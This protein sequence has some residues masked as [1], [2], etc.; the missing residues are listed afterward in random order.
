MTQKHVNQEPVIQENVPVNQD[1]VNEVL[2]NQ[3][4]VNIVISNLVLVNI[5]VSVPNI[6]GVRAWK[7][8]DRTNKSSS[9]DPVWNA[10]AAVIFASVSGFFD[11]AAFASRS[12]ENEQLALVYKTVLVPWIGERGIEDK[13][14]S[15]G[16]R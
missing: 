13:M 11:C 4:P 3:D 12:Q 2:V 7:P 16:G 10:A 5:G 14:R 9:S 6:L 8:S 1:H 15:N